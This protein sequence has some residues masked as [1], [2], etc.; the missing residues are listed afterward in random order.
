M[1]FSKSKVQNI[2]DKSKCNF[3]SANSSENQ[4]E[5]IKVSFSRYYCILLVV[6]NNNR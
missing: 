4:S 2:T 6:N 3:Q 1:E 5:E